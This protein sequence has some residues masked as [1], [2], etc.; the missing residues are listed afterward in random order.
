MTITFA[1]GLLW[2]PPKT[3]LAPIGFFIHVTFP[4]SEIFCSLSV[5]DSRPKVVLGADLVGFRTASY[6]RRFRQTVSCILVHE[7]PP[8]GIQ[9]EGLLFP[10]VLVVKPR[11]SEGQCR[12][13]GNQREGGVLWM[14]VCSQWVSM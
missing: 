14:L 2:P 3:A 13:K 12:G 4:S 5:H 8:K 10:L 1:S 7:S 6:A 9:V 11:K